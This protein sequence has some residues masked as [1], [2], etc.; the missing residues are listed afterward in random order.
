MKTLQNFKKK[1]LSF[2][3]KSTSN[4]KK[5]LALEQKLKSINND[6]DYFLWKIEKIKKNLKY[7]KMPIHERIN[8][9]YEYILKRENELKLLDFDGYSTTIFK[10][11]FLECFLLFEIKL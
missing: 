10:N 2:E 3:K 8:E 7:L 6:K 4:T 5:A 9:K 1:L 11:S